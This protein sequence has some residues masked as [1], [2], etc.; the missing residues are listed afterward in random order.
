[1]KTTEK[2]S[3]AALKTR[4][5]ARQRAFYKL[6]DLHRADYLRIL[7]VEQ[8][9]AEAE[10]AAAALPGGVENYL[11]IGGDNMTAAQAAERLGVSTKTIERYRA[12]LVTLRRA[13]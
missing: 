10:D 12:T 8:R 7:G 3:Y 11:F 1:M 6:A 2:P 9:I 4:M 13:S 5:K